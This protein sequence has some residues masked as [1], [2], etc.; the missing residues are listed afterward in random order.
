[1]R[2]ELGQFSSL[3]RLY[4]HKNWL[5]LQ[6]YQMAQAMKDYRIDVIRQYD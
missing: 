6:V 4:F 1:M 3:L 5:T 2:I